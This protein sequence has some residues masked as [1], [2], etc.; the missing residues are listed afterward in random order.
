MLAWYLSRA[1]EELLQAG[2][3]REMCRPLLG[4]DA[5][6]TF[7]SC[8]PCLAISTYKDLTLGCLQFNFGKPK[9]LEERVKRETVI[10]E[11]SYSIPIALTGR[12]VCP[13]PVSSTCNFA[14]QQPFDIYLCFLGKVHW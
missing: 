5:V 13:G 3:P 4:Y 7:V 9:V 12:F 10:P 14:V 1:E 2:V 11:P 8:L 6:E